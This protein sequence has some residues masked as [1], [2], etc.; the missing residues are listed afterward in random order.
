[1][2]SFN[3]AGHTEVWHGPKKIPVLDNGDEWIETDPY[4]TNAG[5]MTLARGS[6]VV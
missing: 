1:M 5:L 4:E 2:G 6:A 3:D